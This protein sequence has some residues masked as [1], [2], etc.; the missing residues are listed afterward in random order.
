VLFRS[1]CGLAS[2]QAQ[3]F[4][5]CPDRLYRVSILFST[6][7]KSSTMSGSACVHLLL[8]RISNAFCWLSLCLLGDTSLV[9]S[10]KIPAVLAFDSVL[11]IFGKTK[12][13]RAVRS[14]LKSCSARVLNHV[15]MRILHQPR[16]SYLVR[17][18]SYAPLS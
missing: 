8:T 1:R 13:T 16:L 18:G 5:A 9:S 6:S 3:R 11:S 17:D 4:S 2:S 14:I 15:S 12:I 10:P 7:M